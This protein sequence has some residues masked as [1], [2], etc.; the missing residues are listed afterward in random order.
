MFNWYKNIE[1]LAKEHGFSTV[2]ELCTASGV[3]PSVMSNLNKGKAESISLKTAKKFA[4]TMGV[5]V[6]AIYGREDKKITAT[7]GDGVSD[8]D[9]MFIEWFRSLPE[10]KQKAILI[11]Q[12]APEGLL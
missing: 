4:E 12:D 7:S 5:S 8:K 6:D 3:W 11:S 9:K 2:Q 10:E 1:E